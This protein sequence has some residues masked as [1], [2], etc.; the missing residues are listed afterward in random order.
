MA[1]SFAVAYALAGDS[2]ID[3][4]SKS[5]SMPPD[6]R[7]LLSNKPNEPYL[8]TFFNSA[9]ISRAWLDPNP[10]ETNSIFFELINSIVVNN[11]DLEQ[12]INKAN[13][14]ISILLR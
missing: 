1:G 7:S 13:N 9:I 14:Q 11:S 6:T 10:S 3:Q 4:L 5:S 8:N 2:S 12:A